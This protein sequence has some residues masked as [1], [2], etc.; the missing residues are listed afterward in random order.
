MQSISRTLAYIY[1]M[2][3]G[4]IVQ[5][6]YTESIFVYLISCQNGDIVFLLILIN[7]TGFLYRNVL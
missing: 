2:A 1:L 4:Y 6:F 7:L 3:I 5:S